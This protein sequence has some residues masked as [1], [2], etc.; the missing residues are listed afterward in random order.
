[1]HH[2]TLSQHCSSGTTGPKIPESATRCLR[3]HL[4]GLVILAA[5]ASTATGQSRLFVEDSR[6]N[7][8]YFQQN[9]DIVEWVAD[10]QSADIAVYTIYEFMNSGG[11]RVTTVFS[12]AVSDTLE[13]VFPANATTGAVR[14]GILKMLQAGLA[15]HLLR[16]NAP[17]QFVTR[18]PQ[19]RPV[20][21]EN[22][23]DRWKAWVFTTTVSANGNGQATRGSLSKRGSVSAN[24]TTE[25]RVISVRGSINRNTSKFDLP[26]GSTFERTVKS[27]GASGELILTTGSHSGVGVKTGWSQSTY[28][29]TESQWEADA[30]GEYNLFP[31]SESRSKTL[32]FQYRVTLTNYNYVEE[33]L[34]NELKENVLSHQAQ[35]LSAWTQKW[36]SVSLRLAARH[37]LSNF[38]RSLTDTY[39]LSGYITTNL[40]LTRG[41]SIRTS[42]SASRLRD[43]FYLPLATATEEEIL[44]GTVSLPTGWSYF[45]N[46]SL[47]YRFGSIFNSAVNS[48]LGF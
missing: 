4:L 3:R 27:G 21:V 22:R 14:D 41:L 10:R 17:I 7:V 29:N 24:Q 18:A 32:R 20:L 34:F 46:A 37:Y 30:I 8:E 38:D 23:T 47:S 35:V 5:G 13:A 33:T 45:F 1:M 48:R 26:D 11:R 16:Q 36:G 9:L 44:T 25:Q 31:Y 6:S 19:E 2:N 15:S 28:N 42:V 40:R 12:G 43:Q 39:N